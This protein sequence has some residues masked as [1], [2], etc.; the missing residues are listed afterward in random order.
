MYAPCLADDFL[1]FLVSWKGAQQIIYFVIIIIAELIQLATSLTSALVCSIIMELYICLMA[2]HQDLLN[3]CTQQ[4]VPANELQTWRR[5]FRCQEKVLRSVNDY[6]GGP[7]LVLLIM[8]V[9]MLILTIFHTI[10]GKTLDPGMILTICNTII[11]ISGITL[12]S[13]ILS[14]KVSI[15]IVDTEPYWTLYN[16]DDSGFCTCQY[17][18]HLRMYICTYVMYVCMYMYMHMHMHLYVCMH[19]CMLSRI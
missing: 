3:I 13:A 11:V 12:P 5:I 17:N 18:T 6:L 8:C 14:G 7:V 4:Y 9:S 10:D 2:S 19:A 16:I 1:F 15:N